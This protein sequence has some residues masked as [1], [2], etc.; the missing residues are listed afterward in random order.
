[1]SFKNIIILIAFYSLTQYQLFG[2]ASIDSLTETSVIDTIWKLEEVIE[3]ND[4]LLKET[5]GKRKISV[6]IYKKTDETKKGYY[7][8]KVGED[9]GV[10]FVSHYNFF[11]YPNTMKVLY[12]DTVNDL[13]L[14]LDKWRKQ[15][16]K[17]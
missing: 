6:L 3:R 1:M 11:V 10:S 5:L 4:Y 8:L 13:E 14:E 15:E 12:Y 2:Q 9:N 16:N 17:K 7:W